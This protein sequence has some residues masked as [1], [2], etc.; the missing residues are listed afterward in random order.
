MNPHELLQSLGDRFA[1]AAGVKTIYGEPVTL[2]DRTVIPVAQVRYGFGGGTGKT[3][4][5]GG[6]GGGG[7]IATPAGALEISAGSTRFV[8]FGDQR[9]LIAA[10]AAGFALGV[11]LVSL[12]TGKRD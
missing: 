3:D 8:E 12:F 2:G 6:G 7:M 11:L 1:T 9:K 4:E 5:G 10:V